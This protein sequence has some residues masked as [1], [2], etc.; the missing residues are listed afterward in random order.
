MTKKK[1]VIAK[2]KAH[3]KKKQVK[4]KSKV[5]PLILRSGQW[6]PEGGKKRGFVNVETGARISRRQFDKR[7]GRLKAQGFTS[8]ERK[9]KHSKEVAPIEFQHRPARGRKT[10]QFKFAIKRKKGGVTDLIDFRLA[11]P[12]R[13]HFY[14]M[15]LIPF[16]LDALNWFMSRAVMN[17][18]MFCI[19]IPNLL[20]INER[21]ETFFSRRI[22]DC[23]I[24]SE[25]P[26]VSELW[27]LILTL[28][29][30]GG[31][32][33][34]GIVIGINTMI[35]FRARPGNKGRYFA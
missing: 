4:V 1:K 34:E 16:T 25:L 27:N 19:G 20:M 28:S 30:N 9:A 22:L 29:E 14:S 31:E 18:R 11:R 8:Y 3:T 10:Q 15:Y 6:I 7:H 17:K 24:K 21:G 33:S 35:K 13:N 12:H 5:K 23:T 2:A 32:I 26:T